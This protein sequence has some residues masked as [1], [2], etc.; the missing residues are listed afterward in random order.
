MQRGELDLP[1]GGDNEVE[2]REVRQA[3]QRVDVVRAGRKAGG[4][5]SARQ[6]PAAGPPLRRRVL[7][8]AALRDAR[9]VGRLTARG[10]AEAR[11]L[12]PR[13]AAVRARLLRLR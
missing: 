10:R 7:P 9:R 1:D 6:L 13:L 11:S 5:A 12:R 2:L 4:H 3:R 8:D